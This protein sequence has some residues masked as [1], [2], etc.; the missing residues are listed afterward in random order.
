MANTKPRR[1][2][3]RCS[4]CGKSQERVQRLIAGPGGVYICNECVGLCNEIIAGGPPAGGAPSALLPQ[5]RRRGKRR[6]LLACVV[7]WWA[8]WAWRAWRHRRRAEAP[9]SEDAA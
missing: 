4:F 6:L 1:G 8:F 9:A 5:G 2:V 7:A 3:Y